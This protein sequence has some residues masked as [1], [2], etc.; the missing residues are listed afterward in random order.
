MEHLLGLPLKHASE[1]PA[2]S[3][4]ELLTSKGRPPA[5][6]GWQYQFD[7][8]GSR[9][10]LRLPTRERPSTRRELHDGRL[11][12]P[13]PRQVGCEYTTWCS[14][15]ST[16]GGGLRRTEAVLRGGV[17]QVGA[18]EGKPDRTR[19]PHAGSR[20]RPQQPLRAAP[21]LKILCRRDGRKGYRL[22]SAP[23]TST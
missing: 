3:G 1:T 4:M 15:P 16:A 9:P 2:R 20:Q 22:V 5:L 21:S 23:Y 7:I 18:A 19:S 13:K 11:R 8:Y 10:P 14:S 17:S 12:E 6:P